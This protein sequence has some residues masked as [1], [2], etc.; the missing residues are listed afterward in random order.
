MSD[1]CAEP[2]LAPKKAVC[3]ANGLAYPLVSAQ[4]IKHHLAAPWQWVEQ[5]QGYYFCEDPNC[6][7]AYFSQDGQ[8]ISKHALRIPVG[9]KETSPEALICFCFGVSKMQAQTDP[10]IKNYVMA[11]TKQGVC[12]CTSRNPAGRCCL[13]DFPK[14]PKA[15]AAT[16]VNK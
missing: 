14:A 2:A 6:E 11:Q 12:A 10:A 9:I 15:H 8:T 3:P 4:T 5:D 13:K 1:C 16:Q 7:V